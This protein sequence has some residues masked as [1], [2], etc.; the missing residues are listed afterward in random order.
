MIQFENV[1]KSFVEDFWKA[2]KKVLKDLSFEVKVG[3]LCGFLGANGAGK[4]TSLKAALGFI[5]ID[6]GQ[7]NFDSSLGSNFKEV[8]SKVG[9]FPEGPYFYPYMTGRE[10]CH[11][12]GKLQEISRTQIESQVS[13]WGK[14]LNID[15]ALDKKIRAYSKGMLQRLGFLTSLLHDP[16]LIILDEP[17]SGLDPIGR[18]EFK[19]TLVNL[20]NEGKTVFFSSHIVSDVEEICDE[21]IVIRDGELFYSGTTNKILSLQEKQFCYANFVNTANDLLPDFIS[22]S[23]N[24]SNGVTKV[25]FLE[26]KRRGF[27]DWVQEKGVELLELGVERPSLEQVIYNTKK[28]GRDS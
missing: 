7:I 25:S 12:L 3:S 16:K 23:I 18:K 13:K 22:E 2:P 27:L 21:L 14:K 17:L 26:E 5:K 1:N 8:R 9:Y 11:Y 19:E 10:F 20:N 4:T 28:V 6:S 24:L 15:Y